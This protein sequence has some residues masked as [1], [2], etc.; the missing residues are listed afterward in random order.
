MELANARRAGRGKPPEDQGG[1]HADLDEPPQPN[2][3]HHVEQEQQPVD[4]RD[5]LVAD[6]RATV[7]HRTV[8]WA[9][10][11]VV[12]TGLRYS[13]DS[14]AHPDMDD[15]FSDVMTPRA[16]REFYAAWPPRCT[17]SSARRDERPS[18]SSVGP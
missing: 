2:R 1:I 18:G 4:E 7:D 12:G 3:D 10:I 8:N 16:R 5:Q 15:E 9:G 17:R 14:F 13:I 11:W 6:L